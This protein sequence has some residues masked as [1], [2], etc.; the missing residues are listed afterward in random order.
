MS[1]KANDELTPVSSR[2]RSSVWTAMKREAV[3][4]RISLQDALE[5]A[6]LEFLAKRSKVAGRGS[7]K[8]GEK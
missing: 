8:G 1:N 4:S 2:M 7:K 6:C 3:D 5:Q